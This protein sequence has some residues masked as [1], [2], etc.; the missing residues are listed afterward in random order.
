MMAWKGRLSMAVNW[1]LMV[2]GGLLL[3][4]SMFPL[5]YRVSHIGVWIAMGGGVCL[6]GYGFI[7][8]FLSPQGFWMMFDRILL[9]L[10]LLGIIATAVVSGFMLFGYAHYHPHDPVDTVVVLGCKVKGDRPTKMLAHRL[11][12][13]CDIMKDHPESICIV[14]GGQGE[15]EQYPESFVMKQYLISK[16][17]SPERI[18]EEDQSTS[19][20]ENLEYSKKLLG[21]QNP[22]KTVVV[23]D[24]FHLYR[25]CYYARQQGFSVKGAAG[26]TNPLL[27]VSYWIREIP[28][29]VLAW[30]SA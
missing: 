13:A 30:F 22:G 15:D 11:D 18:L 5:C 3:L 26:F 1:I 19:T 4:F 7:R 8:R 17:I 12:T 14:S 28:A 10:I 6:A 9:I 21:K 24:G 2:L 16:G 20:Q 27:I 23:T 25:G 29:V